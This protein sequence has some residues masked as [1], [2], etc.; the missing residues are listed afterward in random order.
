MSMNAVSRR[1][2]VID[3]DILGMALRVLQGIEVSEETLAVDVVDQV[4]PGGH[5][6]M[7]EHTIRHMRS[8]FY[9]PSAVVDRQADGIWPLDSAPE[10]WTRAKKLVQDILNTHQPQPLEPG[11]ERW[12]RQRFE[13]AL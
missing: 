6:L 2:F 3:N 10:L 8:E 4:G 11:V 1:Q 7:S 9:Y 13:L 12:I 5:Y